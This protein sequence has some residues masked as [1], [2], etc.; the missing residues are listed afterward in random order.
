MTSKLVVLSGLPGTG[1]TEIAE[2]VA[3]TL[4]APVFAKDWLEAPIL[5]TGA[6]PRD[7][8]GL[9]GYELLTTLARRQLQFGQSA[10][11]DSVA[12][13]PAI[14]LVWR[15]LVSEFNASWLVI[16][17]VCS[18]PELHRQR[19][20]VRQRGIPGWP[21]LSWAE[22]ER[23]RSYFAPWDEERL[24]L[25]S[26]SPLSENVEKAIAHVGRSAAE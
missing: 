17:C 19:L 4:G 1:K 24:I 5:Q 7:Q 13:L 10:V 26:V 11:L 8:L 16:E 3:R 20:R 12:G 18:D 25:D 14:R 6:V 9:I 22:V 15:E 21:E 23:V 2:A